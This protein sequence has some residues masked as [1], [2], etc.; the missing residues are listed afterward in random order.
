MT[1]RNGTF[2]PEM[3]HFHGKNHFE[4][5]V[6]GRFGREP[7]TRFYASIYAR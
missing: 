6:K 2:A 3:A 1:G 7:M 4:A 5:G